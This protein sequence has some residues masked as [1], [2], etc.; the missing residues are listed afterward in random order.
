M[1]SCS[2]YFKEGLVAL[3]SLSSFNLPEGYP[4]VPV[5][6][7]NW[8]S[9]KK[10][11]LIVVESV[12]RADLKAG[13]LL[14][15]GVDDRG[16][17][18]NSMTTMMPNLVDKAF[19]YYSRHFAGEET[20]EFEHAFGIANFNATRT[21]HAADSGDQLSDTEK[22]NLHLKFARRVLNLVAKM[23]ATHVLVCGFT[24]MQ[25]IFQTLGKEEP[26]L[27]VKS[28]WV[29]PLEHRGHKFF[30]VQTLDLEPLYNPFS[31][32]VGTTESDDE[33]ESGADRFG[34][35]D[36]LYFVIRCL[37]NLF[38]EQHLYDLSW[39]K[40]N[41]VY[42]DT[43]EKWK[44]LLTKLQEAPVIAIDT[45][46]KSLQSYANSIYMIQFAMSA[47]RGYVVPL[48]HP[49]S[50]F[51]PDEQRII[52]KGIRKLLRNRDTRK[53]LVFM[54]G[55]FDLRI[56][57]AQLKIPFVHHRVWEVT[58]GESMLDEN[59]GLFMR[60]KW[61]LDN[62]NVKISYG[63]L[64]NLF[65]YYGND[66][67]YRMPFSKEERGLTGSLPPD[68]PDLLNYASLDAQ[69]L[70]AMRSMQLY[71]AE[72]VYF[73]PHLD[74]NKM[75]SFGPT[76]RR[77][78]EN[79][80]SNTVVS[81]SHM[82]QSGSPI[83]LKYLELLKSKKSPL[84][85]EI[86]NV[87]AELRDTPHVKEFEAQLNE[88]LGKQATLFGGSSQMFIIGKKEHQMKLFLEVMGL[89]PIGFTKT[90]Q[91]S[92]DAVFVKTY[93]TDHREVSLF[94]TYTKLNKLL[95]TYVK[96][97][98]N[99]I[100]QS[101]DSLSDHCLRPRFGFFTVVT[102]RL[103][104]FGPSLQQTP[105]RGPAAKVIKRMFAAPVGCL[106]FKYDYN[107]AEVRMAAVL[108]QDDVM[109]DSFKVGMELR[110]QWIVT[111]TEEIKAELKKKGD[112]HINSVYRFFKIWVDKSHPLREGIKA[113]IFGCIYGLSV[114]S[115]AKKLSTEQIRLAEDEIRKL[116]KLLAATPSEE[117]KKLLK[118]E[119]EK[120][121]ELNERDWVEYA[122]G[123]QDKLFADFAK[124]SE[125]L[126]ASS[127]RVVKDG[128]VSSPIG[129]VRHLYR[130]ITGINGIISAARR[131]AQNGPIQGI[132][133]EIGTTAGY[134][135]LDECDQYI[136]SRR[137]PGN[138]LPD[139]C[140]AVHDANYFVSKYAFL[141]PSLHITAYMA[142]TGAV[143]W[144]ENIFGLR[145]NVHPEVE[146][147]IGAHDM[148]SY[149]WD[150]SMNNLG[151]ILVNSLFDMVAIGRLETRDLRETLDLIYAPWR[152]KETRTYLQSTFPLLNVKNSLETQ[153]KDGMKHAYTYLEKRLAAG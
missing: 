3:P 104:S 108:S 51:T 14:S 98:Y 110:K 105:N 78:V 99:K 148:N 72:N 137:L 21:R 97:W 88:S 123:L 49:Q 70:I 37:A 120:L 38:N 82:E 95:G 59:I 71:R 153:I 92:I 103:N 11:L 112:V 101:V 27:E 90:K 122:Q 139:Y 134:L 23:Q 89:K 119:K 41:P 40:P 96:G 133:S 146:L 58:A 10:R 115:L 135:I 109:A 31:S 8:K 61:R 43:L 131:R 5:V 113:V 22:K 85:Q 33:D 127:E 55:P 136:R 74:S 25:N 124:L 91:P 19:R 63:N 69:C 149:K 126:D 39:V 117:T 56:L 47:K 77:H 16:S 106:N 80:M 29:F 46:T 65:T 118:A 34:A 125:F 60:Y 141:I 87:E 53:D 17:Y 1:S 66:L 114:K 144:Y 45:E 48:Y 102:G 4:L 83:D 68:H 42:I 54:N 32:N 150:W 128:H 129:R 28:G 81:I 76:Y 152:D 13:T 116:T 73:R 9:S 107:A 111:P 138:Y 50:P 57:R 130:V 84:L 30:A 64:R 142:T 100:V 15:M 52:A 94:G 67:Y 145:F 132:S 26:A 24:A 93:E 151:E 62:I 44:K 121:E 18:L 75:E 79:Q 147:E 143:E 86:K 140:R 36:L 6:S 35:S 20:P 7:S 2:G 12:D